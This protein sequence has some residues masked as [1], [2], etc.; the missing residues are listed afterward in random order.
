M[1]STNVNID[2]FSIESGHSCFK[3]SFLL[4]ENQAEIFNELPELESSVPK[5]TKIV[6]LYTASCITR[7]GLA[8]S[9][10]E[11]TFYHKSVH[12]ISIY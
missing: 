12:N 3:C 6:L 9:F 5:E 8:S 4:D 10:N 11:T 7:N 1:R 2:S